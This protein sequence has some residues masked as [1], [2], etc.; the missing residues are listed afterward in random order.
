[1]PV[2]PTAPGGPLSVA[3]L[4]E[5]V[6]T[7]LAGGQVK[8]WEHFADAA[9]GTDPDRLGVD[10]TLYVLGDRPRVE[11]L[12]RAVRFVA[13]RPVLSTAPLNRGDGDVSD[14]APHHPAL[15]R[16]LPRH[17]V[18]H[19]T[20]TLAFAS[21][22][23]RLRRRERRAGRPR[24]TGLVGSVHTDMPA[25]TE[26][27]VRRM[28]GARLDRHP[29]LRALD[30][31][32]RCAALMRRRRDRVLAACDHVLVATPSQEPEMAAL[33][34]GERVSRLGR[35][36]DLGLFRP[37]PDARAELAALGVPP[38]PTAVVFAGRVD[39]S[40]NVL[41]LAAAVRRLRA[42]GGDAHL[43][44]AGAGPDTERIAALLGP[45]ATLLGA[46]PQERLARVLA[47]GDIFALP[48]RTETIG[49][50]VGEAMA[51]GLPVVLPAGTPTNHWL[52]EPGGDGLLVPDDTEEAW[53]AAL[54]LLVDRPD[55]RAAMG[56]RAAA[57]V[58]ARHRTWGRVLTDDLLPVWRGAA[59][60]TPVTGG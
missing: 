16:L 41:L 32:A 23:A 60:R 29:A 28:L 25:L 59:A 22:A 35:G 33:V 52:A 8:C 19:V 4:I 50:V 7:P 57:T 46:L 17:D 53:A 45:G 27:Y 30:P 9:A 34:G 55:L 38:G 31:A 14:L 2:Q 13:L 1:M 11:E 24:P 18:W 43:V 12:S 48:S 47:G 49:N 21:T 39:A 5:L 26:A 44:V 54:G 40:K 56:E 20:H 42:R 10:L 15:A 6:R 51:C 36:L 3:V 58:R 37:D